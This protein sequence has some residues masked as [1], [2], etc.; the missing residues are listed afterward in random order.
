MP[1]STQTTKLQ[2][3]LRLL[4]PRLRL[5]QKKDTASSVAQ[6]REL[7][8]LLENG[9][10]AS[11]RYR[12]ENV[13]A[14]DIGVEVMEI[15]ELYCELLLARAA[16]LDQIAFSEKGVEGRNKAKEEFKQSLEK[17][18]ATPSTPEPQKQSG[19]RGMGWFFSGRTSSTVPD[20]PPHVAEGVQRQ[21]PAAALDE[22]DGFDEEA[23]SY[24]NAGLD[25]A[26]VAIFYA[27][28]RFPR[29]VKELTTLRILLMER[30]G[31]EFATLAQNNKTAIKIPER[32]VKKLRVKP[33]SV[34][35]VESYLREIA[36]AYNVAWPGGEIAEGSVPEPMTTTEEQA[37]SSSQSP[38]P[39][40]DDTGDVAAP[41]HTPRKNLADIRRMSETDELSRA[42]PP[43]DIGQHDA[44]GK[45]PVSVA[46]P[47]PSSDNPEP[48]VKI[49]GDA[50][51][52]PKDLNRRPS[53]G[54]QR[55]DSKG[56][57]DVD[58]LSK[59][60]AALKK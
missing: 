2:S 42:T 59:R 19:G 18:S 30:W 16:V 58:E 1:S 9:R 26:A 46:K 32:L 27:C 25:E 23:N 28:P 13:I 12:V 20:P 45:S 36:K 24:L 52:D 37:P 54:L 47:G 38:P 53:G 29:E 17:K 48:R 31:K 5:L 55:K 14:T 8:Q 56:I 49:P 51:A 39:G 41:P 44:T 50:D 3:T 7:A 11:A 60:F 34:E 40:Y 4:I 33:P 21:D 35:L 15:I 57:P 43:R 6:R 10:E 22:S